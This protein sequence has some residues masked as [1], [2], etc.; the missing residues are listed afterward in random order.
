MKKIAIVYWSATGNTEAMA[1]AIEEGSREEGAKPELFTTAEFTAD[2]VESF[3]RLAF[4]C[5]S[6]G[7]EVLEEDEFEPMFTAVEP[8]LR[9]KEVALFGS[10]GWGD[11]QWMHDWYERCLDGGM[12]VIN[13][14]GLILNETP[15]AEGAEQCKELGRQLAK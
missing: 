12:N 14:E 3:D 2:M 13:G 10:F 11:G 4:G 9:G 5:P 15:D 1:K 7:V 8:A 6:M